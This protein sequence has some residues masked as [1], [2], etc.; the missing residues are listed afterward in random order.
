MATHPRRDRT[1]GRRYGSTQAQVF[2]TLVILLCVAVPWQMFRQ[3][4]NNVRQQELYGQLCSAAER[5]DNA[6]LLLWLRRGANPN[7]PMLRGW[8]VGRWRTRVFWCTYSTPLMAA[9]WHG[10]AEGVR[11]LLAYGA[12]PNTS[13]SHGFSTLDLVN[14]YAP[15]HTPRQQMA[16]TKKL[17][18]K[19]GAKHG[20]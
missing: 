20:P 15:A 8:G 7:G 2:T 6:G 19:A 5:Q 3:H 11:L 13:D 16:L 18:L 12:N 10:N 9:A 17:L 14:Y 4:L 1:R